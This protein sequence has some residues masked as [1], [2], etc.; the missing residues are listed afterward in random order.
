MTEAEWLACTDPTPMLEFLKG[1]ARD[2][3]LRL[4]AC[5]GC[6]LIWKDL[7]DGS[8]KAVEVSE[9]FADGSANLDELNTAR[10]G[11]GME[12]FE[13]IGCSNWCADAAVNAASETDPQRAWECGYPPERMPE[14][15]DIYWVYGIRVE[16]LTTLRVV[17]KATHSELLRDI[18][19][20]PFHHATINPAWITWNERTIPRIAQA[21]YDANAFDRLPIL[22]DALEDAGCDNA[23]I[24]AH[25]RG[26]GPH[27][28]GCWVVDLLLGKG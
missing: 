16:S 26:E 17:Y 4:F 6:R 15:A 18:L 9:R 19:G 10:H 12:L 1:R 21:I 8:K 20:N 13:G 5:A 23:D 2:R 3:K 7:G 11:I 24:F 22:A 25:C 28:R 14:K 27:V